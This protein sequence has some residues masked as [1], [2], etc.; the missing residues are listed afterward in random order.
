MGSAG[1]ESQGRPW[2]NVFRLSEIFLQMIPCEKVVIPTDEE[3]V[4]ARDV[5]R[6]KSVNWNKVRRLRQKAQSSYFIQKRGCPLKKIQSFVRN[7]LCKN[8]LWLLL[9]CLILS[10]PISPH[11]PWFIPFK[12]E[13]MRSRLLFLALLQWWCSLLFI[14]HQDGPSGELRC[15]GDYLASSGEKFFSSLVDG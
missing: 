15:S 6:F 3:L 12:K 7:P 11:H 8:V 10:L 4:I 14:S 13:W 1:F 9:L 5:E 2:K